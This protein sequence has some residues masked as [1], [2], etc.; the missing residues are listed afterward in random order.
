MD[1]RIE[2]DISVY[3]DCIRSDNISIRQLVAKLTSLTLR[4]SNSE[5]ANPADILIRAVEFHQHFRVS[6]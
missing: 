3:Q 2:F 6:F 4:R 1:P 5:T